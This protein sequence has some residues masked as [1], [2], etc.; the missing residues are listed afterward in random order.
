M[1]EAPFNDL[2]HINSSGYSESK[3]VSERILWT[4]GQSTSLRPVIVRVGQ[5]CGGV[6][7]N[8]NLK[9]W[10]PSLVRAGQV[11]GGLPNNKGV[12]YFPSHVPRGT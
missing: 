9:E 11:V 8:W 7:G 3:W 6:N 12:C 10:F 2:A 5:L 1:A 4:A